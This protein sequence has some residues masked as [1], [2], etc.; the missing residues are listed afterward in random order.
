MVAVAERMRELLEK[1][2]RDLVRRRGELLSGALAYDGA[3]SPGA[4]VFS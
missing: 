4:D 1:R 3:N 2:A